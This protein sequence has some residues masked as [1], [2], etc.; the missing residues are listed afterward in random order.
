MP[1]GPP[2][3]CG[4]RSAVWLPGCAATSRT[5]VTAVRYCSAAVACCSRSLTWPWSRTFHAP[6][7]TIA[8]TA[9][10]AAIPGQRPGPAPRALG[11]GGALV[12]GREGNRRGAFGGRRRGRPLGRGS[13]GEVRRGGG[14][15]P[16]AERGRR[17]DQRDVR[18][19]QQ[20]RHD[21]AELLELGV[22]LG[23]RREVLADGR[24]LGVVERAQ[25]VER[26]EIERLGVRQRGRLHRHGVSASPASAAS[27]V[28][29]ARIASSP[30][31]TRLFTVPSG[32]PVRS[33]ISTWVRPPK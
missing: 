1:R 17:L 28:S 18:R 14:H 22:G 25:D 16:V 7:T 23:A 8:S 30:S 6:R 27:P 13:L 10:I 15:D 33:A 5:V 4:A 29:A 11:P 9:A 26:G 19:L 31:R 21:P 12:R 2:E 24:H 32:V 20:V 3:V